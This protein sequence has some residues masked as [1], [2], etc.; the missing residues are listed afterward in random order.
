[1]ALLPSL[2]FAVPAA[3]LFYISA[4]RVVAKVG[5]AGAT[6]DDAYIHFQYARAFAE[7]HPL[8]YYAGEAASSGVQQLHQHLGGVRGHLPCNQRDWGGCQTRR[9]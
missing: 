7:G 5:H 1:M 8:R 4:S 2:P 9:A 3:F 6:L